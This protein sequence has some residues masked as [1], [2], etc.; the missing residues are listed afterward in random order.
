MSH[1]EFTLTRP[2]L[3]SAMKE[4]TKQNEGP[5]GY[6]YVSL[7]LQNG[8]VLDALER[9]A[10]SMQIKRSNFETNN[11][12]LIWTAYMNMQ[13]YGAPG[14]PMLPAQTNGCQCQCNAR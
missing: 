4:W 11:A 10:T 7:M 12:C 3:E 5:I 1:D 13:E 6:E 14:F 8:D 2:L 9:V